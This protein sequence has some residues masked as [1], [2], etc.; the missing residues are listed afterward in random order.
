MFSKTALHINSYFLS[1]KIHYNLYK[2]LL[3][4]RKDQF[5]I[6]VYKHFR[7]DDIP[8]IDI[9]YVFGRI[10]KTIFVTKVWKVIRLF[11]KKKYQDFSYLH[12][13]TLMS[14]G[15]PTYILSLLKKK[16][17]VVSV[18]ITDITL[19]IRRSV[20][21]KAI[22]RIILTKAKAVFFIS[23]SLKVKIEEIYPEL[24]NKK[25]YLLPNGLAPYWIEEEMSNRKEKKL[26]EHIRLL[27]VGQIIPRKNLDILLEFM[28]RKHKRGYTLTIVG[29]NTL[30]MDFKKINKQ[31]PPDN[32]VVYLGK[33]N[34][35]EELKTVYDNN[36]I[37]VLLSKSETFGAVYTEA[38]SRGLPIIYTKGEGMD[39][40]FEEGE[41]G[42][43]CDSTSQEELAERIEQ[44]IPLY[45]KISK[46]A[47]QRSFDFEWGKIV[48]KY[49][50]V[51]DGK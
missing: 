31:L 34:S 27:F 29:E 48:D 47:Y 15:I 14:D 50:N 43:S 21:F 3:K 1:N 6:P 33:L 13:H 23:P 16:E 25:F 40:F 44:I 51:I 18:R 28:K 10:D 30:E 7:D 36:D 26:N 32:K 9:D 24:D 39:G 49:I 41:V 4:K 37:F 45:Q 5:L 20:I 35:K 11:Y 42:F 17:Y 38:I 46:M 8:G 2:E 22:G 19:F 12:G